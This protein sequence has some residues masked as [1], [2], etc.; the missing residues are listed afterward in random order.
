M[1]FMY[2]SFNFLFD[3][4]EMTIA[5]LSSYRKFRSFFFPGHIYY[6]FI[7]V[8]WCRKLERKKQREEA[9]K[10]TFFFSSDLIK[11]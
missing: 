8:S 5:V 10:K 1:K 4:L 9:K 11:F 2:N 6:I 7:V 3:A